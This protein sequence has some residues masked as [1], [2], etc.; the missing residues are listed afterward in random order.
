MQPAS[1]TPPP[2]AKPP[3]GPVL[4]PDQV[5]DKLFALI[6][7]LHSEAD[8]N[9]AHIEQVIGLPLTKRPESATSQYVAGDTNSNWRYAFDFRTYGQSGSLLNVS[10]W[11]HNLDKNGNSPICT[12]PL[13]KM[14]EEV[15][16]R[17]FSEHSSRTASSPMIS[18]AARWH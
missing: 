13:S 4:T 16:R 7:S 2:T 14:R 5:W 1:E 3:D 6:D 12:Y 8:L 9:Q 17:G 15:Q 18:P 11:P 10:T